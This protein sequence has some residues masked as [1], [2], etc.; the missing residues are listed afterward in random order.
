[1]CL[2]ISYGLYAQESR[3][4]AWS[5]WTLRIFIFRRKDSCGR[6]KEI[7]KREF[8]GANLAI[9]N[10]NERKAISHR[11]RLIFC[12]FLSMSLGWCAAC[13]TELLFS[14][15]ASV[16]LLTPEISILSPWKAGFLLLTQMEEERPK[17][18]LGCGRCIPA[19]TELLWETMALLEI[20]D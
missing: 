5:I 11:N 20:R 18:S 8:T 6:E 1:M 19:G 13:R 3:P 15:S 4:K 14:A 2:R 9:I 12:Y 16:D 17:R 10:S 7:V